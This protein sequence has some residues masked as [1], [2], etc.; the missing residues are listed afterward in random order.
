MSI[1]GG[2]V[3]AVLMAA[4]ACAGEPPAKTLWQ[5]AIGT[6]TPAETYAVRQIVADGT[7]GCSFISSKVEAA[8][9]TYY[10]VRLDKSGTELWRVS[11]T[12][13]SDI[14]IVIANGK[15]TVFCVT[16]SG[17]NRFMM[18]IDK[19]NNQLTVG[20]SDVNVYSNVN[21]SGEFGSPC[22]KKGFFAVHYDKAA[23]TMTLC[24]HSFKPE[25]Q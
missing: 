11:F 23:K 8:A 6:D 25:T 16:M 12:D 5:V 22:D 15:F 14:D 2:F 4:W 7:G 17:G 10:V 1:I 18:A 9:T 19:K 21:D 3:A 13:L 24:R 20:D